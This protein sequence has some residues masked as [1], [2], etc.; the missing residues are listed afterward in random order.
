MRELH[1]ATALYWLSEMKIN[2]FK[3]DLGMKLIC[4]CGE[5]IHKVSDITDHWKYGRSKLRAIWL[6][7]LIQ[8]VRI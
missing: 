6:F 8:F 5:E 3:G 4:G 7:L 2:Q 1:S